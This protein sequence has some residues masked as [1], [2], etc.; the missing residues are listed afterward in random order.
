MT[1]SSLPLRSFRVTREGLLLGLLVAAGAAVRLIGIDFCLPQTGCRPDEITL[2]SKAMNF[3]SGDL[4]PHF[5]SYPSF[6]MYVLFGLYN[7]YFVAGMVVGRFQSFQ[8]FIAEYAMDPSN[9]FLMSRGLSALLGSLS[10]VAVY[11][12]AIRFFDRSVA[13]MSAFFL[14]FA[15]LHVRDSH[16]GTVDVAAT[17]LVIWSFVFIAAAYESSAPR[18]YGLAGILAGLATSTKYM[19]VLLCAPAAFVTILQSPP[20]EREWLRFFTRRIFWFGLALVGAG[21]A[22][23]PLAPGEPGQLR[24]AL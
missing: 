16:F 12:I 9:F 4:N 23:T 3:F 1:P 15:Y 14:A 22:G 2:I 19:G 24:G 8:D 18:H 13:W 10:I 6:L 5:F 17:F 21:A 7:L 20:G 11:Q